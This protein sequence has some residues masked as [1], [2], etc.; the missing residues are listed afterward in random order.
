MGRPRLFTALFL[1]LQSPWASGNTATDNGRDAVLKVD[2]YEW[3]GGRNIVLSSQHMPADHD[4]DHQ[5]GKAKGKKGR[6]MD[7]EDAEEHP[8]VDAL[9]DRPAWRD[10]VLDL[11]PVEGEHPCF[12]GFQNM[13]NHSDRCNGWVRE[14]PEVG[15]EVTFLNTGLSVNSKFTLKAVVGGLINVWLEAGATDLH[16]DVSIKAANIYTNQYDIGELKPAPGSNSWME[17]ECKIMG[18]MPFMYTCSNRVNILVQKCGVENAWVMQS[19][20]LRNF[21][22]PAT[23]TSPSNFDIVF[24][25]CQDLIDANPNPYAAAT[26][27]AHELAHVIQG[28]FGFSFNTMT[29]GG[30]TWLE[31]PLLNL[32]P[33]PMVYA[34]GFRDW[35]RI[36]A[37]H[38]YANTHELN[39]RKFYQ[40]HSMFLTYLSQPE[41]LGEHSTSAL[42]N[43]Q[44]F[45][46]SN[47]PFGRTAYDY[48]LTY[49]GKPRPD[50]FTPVT[51]DVQ[52]TH[53]AFATALL[54]YRVAIASQCIVN[55]KLRPSEARY[56]M[57]EHLR[58]RPY[59]DCSSYPTYWSTSQASVDGAKADIHYGGAAVFR[60]AMPEGAT[61][62]LA[63]D[64][65]TKIRTK[66]LA[67][68]SASSD[69][70]AEVRELTPGQSMSFEGGARDI[71]VVQVNVDPEGEFFGPHDRAQ[72]WRRSSY[73]C[74]GP[75]EGK[76]WWAGSGPGK[77]Y[78]EN[79][80]SA[81]RSPIFTLPA[82][83]AGVELALSFRAM[84]DL[85]A[86]TVDGSSVGTGCPSKGYDGV[87]VRMHVYGA[88]SDVQDSVEVLTPSSGYGAGAAAESGLHAFGSSGLYTQSSPCSSF[89]GWT[90]SS[91]DDHAWT[92]QHF[93]LA[94]FAGKRVRFEFFFA[95]DGSDAGEG[96][97]VNGI[98]VE[99]G[100][101]TVFAEGDG[102][103]TSMTEIA[104]VKTVSAG[105]VGKYDR[106]PVVAGVPEG[107]ESDKSLQKVAQTRSAAWSATWATP[108]RNSEAAK[109]RAHL[110]W[111]YSAPV[112]EVKTALLHPGQEA[113]VTLQAPFKGS[114]DTATLFLL[115]DKMGVS[116]V[117]LALR[118]ATAP[119]M[120][121][122]GNKALI[123]DSH[124]V[125]DPGT[126]RFKFNGK[127]PE[128]EEGELFLACAGVGKVKTLPADNLGTLP[129][130]HLPLT[131]ITTAGKEGS[132]GATKLIVP[133]SLGKARAFQT[134]GLDPWSGHTFVLRAEFVEALAQD[135]A[136]TVAAA[137]ASWH[138]RQQ[139]WCR[140]ACLRTL[141]FEGRSARRAET[142]REP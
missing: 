67:S 40:I 52:D 127:G 32:P 28:G 115:V 60:L 7:A 4:D 5:G 96:F 139:G 64:A 79:Q 33:R 84:W 2:T 37:A 119:H 51:I 62:S 75:C 19:D 20:Y 137:A 1:S 92:Q 14:Y 104:F 71:Y 117:S 123:S 74:A 120:L 18:S 122:G 66:V 86:M 105:S 55:A 124:G 78:P 131:N 83:D 63:A 68:G 50:S 118:S 106:V 53:N 11:K 6:R 130:L 8:L 97:W 121:L 108:S 57:P 91:G 113:C 90:G 73:R 101:V 12:A 42:Q 29:E 132:P 3:L 100:G 61:V 72:L 98:K 39:S 56:L 93:S 129:F 26:T 54:D 103:D 110:G 38:I 15:G 47:T 116:A 88:D 135:K 99:A 95:S 13:I 140:H 107:Y 27:F 70:K 30:A 82:A 134:T 34:W 43:Y 80:H 114:L 25:M 141:E 59:W 85:E 17:H 24:Y 87:Q 128:L 142:T 138:P 9:W 31:G 21:P 45:E 10:H 112:M 69:H 125:A 23:K 89:E 76:A 126:H 48:F 16:E 44:T 35:N 65:D 49:L 41:L 109:R 77:E 102:E 111:S 133:P 46:S 94:A 36:N 81:L 136:P 58:E 22:G